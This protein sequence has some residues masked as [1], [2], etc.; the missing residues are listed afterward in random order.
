MHDSGRQRRGQDADGGD[1][2]ACHRPGDRAEAAAREIDEAPD[3][4]RGERQ[5]E[6]C[7][8]EG[9]SGHAGAGRDVDREAGGDGDG[10]GEQRRRKR[11][12]R[13]AEEGERAEGRGEQAR[14]PEA[15]R[16]ERDESAE[17][18]GCRAG[19]GEAA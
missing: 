3:E 17:N 11:P 18:D 16:V 1:P 8:E 10:T 6:R 14:G 5:S 19:E 9:K 2:R 7:A 13:Q 12:E 4:E 15:G